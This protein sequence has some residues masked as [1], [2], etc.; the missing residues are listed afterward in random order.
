MHTR[1]ADSCSGGPVRMLFTQDSQ[2]CTGTDTLTGRENKVNLAV[3]DGWGAGNSL[4]EYRW[5]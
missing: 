2:P 3:T 4:T 1:A 5:E